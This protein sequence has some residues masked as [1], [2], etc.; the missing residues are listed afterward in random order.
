MF[1]P[2]NRV[3]RD[4]LR[5][6]DRGDRLIRALNLVV[7]AGL[8]AY[9]IMLGVNAALVH[10]ETA[11]D[12][13]RSLRS[14]QSRSHQKVLREVCGLS[15]ENLIREIISVSASELLQPAKAHSC[16]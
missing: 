2:I 10:L 16:D 13:A 9:P 12:E 3:A 7:G 6:L 5:K 4:P 11:N 15:D 1:D 14:D 8:N